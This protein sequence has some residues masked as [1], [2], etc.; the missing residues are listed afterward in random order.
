[1]QPAIRM[2]LFQGMETKSRYLQYEDRSGKAGDF[3]FRDKSGTGLDVSAYSLGSSCLGVYL[4]DVKP[5]TY[6]KYYLLQ[7][8]TTGSQAETE[9]LT[10][11]LGCQNVITN[12][13]ISNG[14]TRPVRHMIRM[15]RLRERGVRW[16]KHA[17]Q[18]EEKVNEIGSVKTCIEIAS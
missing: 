4:K 6:C 9:N 2:S 1:M 3:G 17:A 13:I 12:S 10:A 7:A 16:A 11:K 15:K 8:N 14:C 5:N 18:A